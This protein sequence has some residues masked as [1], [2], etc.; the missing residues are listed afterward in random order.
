VVVLRVA[1]LSLALVAASQGGAAAAPFGFVFNGFAGCGHAALQSQCAGQT[2]TGNR[3]S[4]QTD[5]IEN[6]RYGA[7]SGSV[8][9]RAFTR[10]IGNG[11]IAFTGQEGRE[12][13]STTEQTGN[14]NAA[15]T[16]QNG[17]NQS[18]QTM[19]SGNATWSASSSIGANTHT[20]VSLN[21]F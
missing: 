21:T 3:N 7:G 4:A 10:Q 12:Q 11:N 6:T 5:Q 18:S 15:F 16:Y 13:V 1:L 17:E 20:S 14:S 9:Q 2:V 8:R 19:E